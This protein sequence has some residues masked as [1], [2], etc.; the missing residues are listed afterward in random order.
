VIVLRFAVIGLQEGE[1]LLHGLPALLM[2]LP[3]PHDQHLPLHHS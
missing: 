3:P 1:L 2:H